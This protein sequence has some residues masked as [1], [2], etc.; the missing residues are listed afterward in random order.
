ML[1]N[2]TNWN[3]IAISELNMLALI[4]NAISWIVA[5]YGFF[6][7][8]ALNLIQEQDFEYLLHRL[9]NNKDLERNEG[10]YSLKYLSE[11][12]PKKA[13]VDFIGYL[14]DNLPKANKIRQLLFDDKCAIIVDQNDYEYLKKN[15]IR[16]LFTLQEAVAKIKNQ[17]FNH[18]TKFYFYT[19]NGQK[20]FNF[21]YHLP[22][23]VFLVLYPE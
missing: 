18:Y 9:K 1:V 12:N 10:G 5:N 16:R 13:L 22:Y 20:D 4:K 17:S 15:G 19:F 11:N 3:H 2:T 21:L 23:N 6:L 7:R 8:L 14:K